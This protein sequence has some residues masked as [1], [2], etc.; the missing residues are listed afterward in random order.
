MTTCLEFRRRVG[1]EPAAPDADIEAHRR[2]CVACARYQD[3]LRAMDGVI[4]RAMRVEPPPREAAATPVDAAAPRRRLYAIAASLVAGVAIGIVL[5]VSAP[6]ESVAREV[7]GHVMHE[8]GTMD[9]T[10]PLLPAALA[11]VLDPDGTRLKPGIG[12][13]TFAARCKFDGHVVPHLVVRTPSGPVTVLMLRHR[14][15]A[16]PM[17]IAEQG[18]EGVV[19]PAPKGSIA[20]VGEGIPDIDAVAR[21]V[22]DAVAWGR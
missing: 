13:V 22:Y 18:Y 16:R 10:E 19:L 15:I 14:V 7:F 4:L 5:L 6:R 12:D 17:H 21:Q 8:T 9:R 2:D 20:V 3:E 1:A 11:G